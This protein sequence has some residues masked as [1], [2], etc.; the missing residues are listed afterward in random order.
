MGCWWSGLR[1]CV[2]CMGYVGSNIF[3]VDHNFYVVCLGQ[4]FSRGSKFSREWFFGCGGKGGK[5]AFLKNI[6]IGTF[7]S[8]FVWILTAIFCIIFSSTL[9]S[10]RKA[11]VKVNLNKGN[12]DSQ[13]PPHSPSKSNSKF[14]ILLVKFLNEN[15]NES[16]MRHFRP[17]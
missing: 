8:S 15:K 1:G 10:S 11:T 3:S 14:E 13:A 9:C 2:S 12:Q 7:I 16:K 17:N 5:G 6:R 4:N